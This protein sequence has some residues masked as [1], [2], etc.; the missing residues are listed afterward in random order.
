MLMNTE[1]MFP[2][3]NSISPHSKA[4]ARS[5]RIMEDTVVGVKFWS[6]GRLGKVFRSSHKQTSEQLRKEAEK[7]LKCT[8]LRTVE[9]HLRS[10]TLNLTVWNPLGVISQVLRRHPEKHCRTDPLKRATHNFRK[11]PK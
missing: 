9:H 3:A 7:I 4:P 2:S 6:Y 1:W 11:I 8:Y 5:Q 10:A